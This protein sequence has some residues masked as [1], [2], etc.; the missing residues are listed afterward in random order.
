[1]I[2]SFFFASCCF[3]MQYL[4]R[5]LWGDEFSFFFSISCLSS[6][7]WV[8]LSIYLSCYKLSL[9]IQSSSVVFTIEQGN[10]T[11][12]GTFFFFFFKPWG[13]LV[14]S[15]PCGDLTLPVTCCVILGKLSNHSFPQFF[16]KLFGTLNELIYHVLTTLC[17]FYYFYYD[18]LAETQLGN[19]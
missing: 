19:F 3:L 18:Y 13:L 5:F 16:L 2:I 11:L 9:T 4:F 12:I 14:G 8:T 10:E 1:M 17:C 7:L 6:F 15:L